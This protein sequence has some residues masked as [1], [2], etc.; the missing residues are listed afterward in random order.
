MYFFST[1]NVNEFKFSDLDDD[2]VLIEDPPTQPDVN[3]EPEANPKTKGWLTFILDR[4][5]SQ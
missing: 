2:V 5:A 1:V 4:S 3:P